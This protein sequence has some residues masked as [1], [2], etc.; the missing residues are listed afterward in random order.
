VR[1]AR[2]RCDGPQFL[3]QGVEAVGTV[4]TGQARGRVRQEPVTV[5]AN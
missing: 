1:A 5:Q 2:A 4:H 3:D